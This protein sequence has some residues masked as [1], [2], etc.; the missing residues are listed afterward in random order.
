MLTRCLTLFITMM[1]ALIHFQASGQAK[2]I[3]GIVRDRATRDVIVGAV[4]RNTTGGGQATNSEGFFEVSISG[5]QDSLLVSMI[6]YK[7]K[8]FSGS[9]I[10]GMTVVEL[11]LSLT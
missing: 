8:S 7:A 5:P 6:G 2:S 11:L 10:L 1:C 4:V 3:Q 9:E